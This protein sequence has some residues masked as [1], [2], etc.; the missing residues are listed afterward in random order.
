MSNRKRI[1]VHRV[2]G[3][4]IAV[5]AYVGGIASA[6]WIRDTDVMKTRRIEQEIESKI[7]EIPKALERGNSAYEFGQS[8]SAKINELPDRNKRLEW[9]RKA[10]QALFETDISHLPPHDQYC[11]FRAINDLQGAITAGWFRAGGTDADCFDARVETF[12]WKIR[13]IEQ[14][15][16]EYEEIKPRNWTKPIAESLFRR[17]RVLKGTIES[18]TSDMNAECVTFERQFERDCHKMP[19]EEQ[20]DVKRKFEAVLG[21]PIRTMEQIKMDQLK[22]AEAFRRAEEAAEAKTNRPPPLILIDGT[23]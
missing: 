3:L 16:K 4:V 8:V 19:P 15:K 13:H 14:L 23:K 20:A 6:Y 5:F 11:C 18:T 7:A 21:R 1:W 12:A 9:Y 17:V 10:V 22:R 2:G